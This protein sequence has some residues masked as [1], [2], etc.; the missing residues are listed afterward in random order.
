MRAVGVFPFGQP[1]LERPALRPEGQARAF[2]LGVYP[3]A[4]H[5]RWRLRS[6]G[7]VQALAVDVEPTVFWKGATDAGERAGLLNAWQLAVGFGEG[8]G[9][10]SWAELNGSSGGTLERQILKP[11]KL[12]WG[13]VWATDSYPWFLIKS[14]PRDQGAR[15]IDTYNPFALST[16]NRDIASL[17][18][19][20]RH[21]RTLVDADRGKR[22]RREVAE[23]RAPWVITLGQEA[24]DVLSSVVEVEAPAGGLPLKSSNAR[25]GM[26]GRISALGHRAEW[27][28]LAHPG[29]TRRRPWASAHKAFVD[30]FAARGGLG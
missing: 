29:A 27:L 26:P 17:L 7:R 4:V 15:I 16:R 20:P 5:V 6:G 13:H 12:Q 23:S 2:I 30:S 28:A 19:R 3:S 25:Y 21:I 11:L 24:A 10:V 18:P 14:G 1:N 8:D 9:R 22:I